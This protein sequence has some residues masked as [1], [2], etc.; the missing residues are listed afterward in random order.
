MNDDF[1]DNEA[2][3]ATIG[4][5]KTS[6]NNWYINL[7]QGSSIVEWTVMH[8]PNENRNNLPDCASL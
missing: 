7:G 1:F 6:S 5:R 2:V 3:S 8:G 4:Q